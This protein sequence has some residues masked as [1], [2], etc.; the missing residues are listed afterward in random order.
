M[1][2]QTPRSGTRAE[3]RRA[4]I[5]EDHPLFC[6][7]LAMTLQAV[8]GIEQVDHADRLAAAVEMIEAGVTP[9]VIVLDLNLPDVNGL[10]GLMR[11]RL[12]APS[13]PIVVVS[14]ID[15]PRVIRSAILAGAAGFVPKH[16]RRELFRAAF[17]AIARGEVFVPESNGEALAE[18]NGM[19]AQDEAIRRLSQLTRQQAKILEQICEGKM[20]KQIAFDLSIAETTVKAHV[21][22]IMRKL[23]VYSRTQAVLIAREA[24]ATGPLPETWRNG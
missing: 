11:L 3:F 21:T 24:Q 9:D 8:A 17:A 2:I 23:G 6:D 7:A 4:M 15:E 14:S 10:D 22:A 12:A 20:N 19:S 16:S 1:H 13:L 18:G 5:V